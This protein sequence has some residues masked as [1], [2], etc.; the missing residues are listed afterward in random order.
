MLYDCFTFYNELDL[1]EARLHELYDV[2]DRFVLVEADQTFKGKPKPLYFRDN[3][4]TFAKY[5][6]KITHVVIEF[7]A[8]DLGAG[9]TTRPSNASWARQYYQ[10]DQIGRGLTSATPD[11]LIIVS[12][13]DELISAPKLREA[14]A[15]R[16]RHELTI[17][18]MPIYTGF[19]NSRVTG[20]V[21]EKGPRMIE[22]S[23]FPGAQHLRLTKMTASTQLG[24]NILSRAY[25]RYQNYILQGVG[26]R[27]RIIPESGWHMT[28]IGDYD[29]FCDKMG[30]ISGRQK[31]NREALESK[32]AFERQ[33]AK[34]T[35]AVC[36]SELPKFIRDNPDRFQLAS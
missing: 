34:T 13:V 9:L 5:A 27:I 10:R 36:P 33:L 11:D 21:W 24:N 14:I 4:A 31:M 35:T 8:G 23:E 15:T 29:R 20:D 22:F 25:T 12:D 6:D 17:F 32:E 3:A 7:P 16:R 30:A 2:V 18:E 1:L 28:S 26:N 19:V